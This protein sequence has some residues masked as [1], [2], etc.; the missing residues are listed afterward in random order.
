MDSQNVLYGELAEFYEPLYRKN[1]DDEELGLSYECDLLESLFSKAGRPVKRVLDAGC[2]T[3][4]HAIELARRG[5]D[6]TGFDLSAQ[7]LEIAN[8]RKMEACSGARF[9]KAGY[10]DF[11]LG[12]KFDAIVSMHNAIMCLQ[13]PQD[14][15]KALARFNS[16]LEVG[17]VLVIDFSDYELMK[18]LGVFS[19]TFVDR[20]EKDGKS[21]VE[22]SE[23]SINAEGGVVEERNTYFASNDGVNFKR[24]ETVGRQVLLSL[25]RVDDFF[26]RA[27]FARAGAIDMETGEE[28]QGS[29]TE[30]MVAA[31]K[32]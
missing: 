3:G 6:A 29:S 16:A 12:E 2:G 17:G 31:I 23:N 24:F 19:E 9:F 26:A 5:F 25:E 1:L 15:E 8:K 28:A 4:I 27:G 10:L 14:F 22:V 18:R 21:V 11:E 7:M 30:L 13:S 20:F 32:Q